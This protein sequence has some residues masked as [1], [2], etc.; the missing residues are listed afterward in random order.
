MLAR[1]SALVDR[2]AFSTHAL[3]GGTSP[4]GCTQAECTLAHCACSVQC[5]QRNE[6][7]S[8]P[9]ETHLALLPRLLEAFFILQRSGAFPGTGQQA[10][11]D[12]QALGAHEQAGG[13]FP[14]G[15]TQA[16]CEWMGLGEI[17]WDW[18]GLDGV[19]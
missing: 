13:T 5:S 2:Q 16:G 7:L 1:H 19:G 12:W 9:L 8:Q 6:F 14:D 15:C 4:N 11:V 17:G 18:L 3:A 10:P